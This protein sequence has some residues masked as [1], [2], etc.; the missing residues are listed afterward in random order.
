MKPLHIEITNLG[1]IPHADI[2]LSNITMAAISGVNGAGKSTA[3]TI[4]PRFA[5]YGAVKPG[6]RADD[7]VRTGSTEMSVAFTFEHQGD[8]W[9]VIRTRST[10]GRGKSTLELQRQKNT[11]LKDGS[12]DWETKSGAS[13][14]ETQK[15]II[16]LLGLDDETFVASSMILQGDA[17]NFTKR[18]AGQRKA[19]LAQILQLDQYS[20]LQDKAK[21]KAG[22]VNMQL[23]KLKDR[24]SDIDDRLLSKPGLENDRRII[25]DELVKTDEE[26]QAQEASVQTLQIEYSGLVAKIQQAD[27]LKRQAKEKWAGIGTKSMERDREQTR[28]D[29]AQKL[30]DQEAEILAAVTQF[31]EVKERVTVLKTKKERQASL[32]AEADRLKKELTDVDGKVSENIST[33]NEL[34]A[35]LIERPRLEAAARDHQKAVQE[36]DEME[37]M[38]QKHT[39]LSHQLLVAQGKLDTAVMKFANKKAT[40]QREISLLD[41]KTKLLEQAECLDIENANCA[42]LRDAKAAQAKVAELRPKLAT[43]ENPEEAALTKERD[44][45]QHEIDECGFDNISYTRLKALVTL[46][47]P[48]AEAFGKLDG[49]AQLLKNLEG[50]RIDLVARQNDIHHRLQQMREEYAGLSDGL[51]ELPELELKLVQLEPKL[52]LKDR[53]AAA[54]EI[55][56]SAGSLVTRLN[57]EIETLTAQVLTLEKE[58]AALIGNSASLK[59]QAEDKIKTA[60]DALKIV[61]DKH[62]FLTGHIGGI[63][64]KLSALEKD[65]I[66]RQSIVD[67]MAPLSKQLVRW[68]TLVKA[69][70]RDGIPALIIENAVPELERISN[71]IL[72]Q[73]SGGR[74]YLRF[75]TQ[76]ENKSGGIAETL[77][78]I[79]GDWAGER[80]YETFSGGEQLRIDFAIRFALAELL[81]R[82][83]GS[84]IDCL[85][86]DEGFG[87]QSDEFLPMVVEA[88]KSVAHRFGLVLVISHVR[89]VQEAFEQRIEFTPA[90]DEGAPIEVKVA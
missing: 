70:G 73:M 89:A 10:K 80:I 14:D 36:L 76:K 68:Q 85:V 2:D 84:R 15:K 86:I 51:K 65:E 6:T 64:A 20:D 37:K 23:E 38:Q 32:A 21:D 79:V 27:E 9:R 16:D 43:M 60:Q 17:G 78:I 28:I 3:F 63:R 49:Q 4:A 29:E 74:N 1:A 30:L 24:V 11:L 18:P 5:L 55:V 67:E 90:A 42:F 13:I 53:L 22:E 8:I 31:D 33:I 7:N 83:A 54:K 57:S 58:Y 52:K 26:I 41:E 82:R 56:S 50:Q 19:I 75:E 40:M 34:Q 35:A 44:R 62:T 72:G 48:D 12:P 47:K 71:D 39:E 77:D 88:V 61:R 46:L 69:F 59:Q 66:D 25:E 87:S 45:L 81:T